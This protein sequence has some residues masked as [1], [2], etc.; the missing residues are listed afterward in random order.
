MAISDS[1]QKKS[2]HFKNLEYAS[3]LVY[4]YGIFYF[5]AIII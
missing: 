1:I 4:T 2:Y 5:I 3:H